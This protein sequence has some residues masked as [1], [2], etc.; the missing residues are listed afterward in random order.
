V[1]F[2]AGEFQ[3]GVIEPVLEQPFEGN[4]DIKQDLNVLLQTLHL[5]A[6]DHDLSLGWLVG[7]GNA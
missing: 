6:V 1:S 4:A 3:F 7:R 2:E 5:L